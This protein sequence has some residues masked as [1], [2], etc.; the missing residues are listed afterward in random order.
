MSQN[1]PGARGLELGVAIS[2]LG[3]VR[4]SGMAPCARGFP[5]GMAGFV[6]HDQQLLGA[7][8]RVPDGLAPSRS[9][10]QIFFREKQQE[11]QTKRTKNRTK[12]G[13]DALK[14]DASTEKT[15]QL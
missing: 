2:L 4:K 11:A 14:N 15:S 8:F 9:R 5:A 3:P 10:R 6:W 13:D 1:F 7:V 12:N